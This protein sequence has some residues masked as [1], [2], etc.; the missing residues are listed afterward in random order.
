MSEGKDETPPA[1]SA[2]PAVPSAKAGPA[3]ISDPLIRQEARRAFVWLGMASLVA[4]C[5][6]L[7][8]PL[9]VIFGGIVFAAMI[10]GGVRLLGR[11][12]KIGHGWRVGIVLLLAV[13]FLIWTA[14]FAG[15]QIARQAAE[16]PA[17]L[18]S[19][20][21]AVLGWLEQQQLGLEI[22]QLKDIAG[23]VM[24]GIGQLSRAVGGIIGI[25]TT[26]FLILVLGI[27]FALEPH[28]YSRGVGWMLPR[29]RR[30]Y[31]GETAR[32]MGRSLRR[33]LAG[34]L[35]GMAITGTLTW[36]MLGLYG[37]PMAALLGLLTGLLAF[38]PNI[39]ALISGILIVLVGFSGG[40][41]MGLYAIFVYAFI[42]TVDGFIIGPQVARR[43]ADLPPALVLGAQL[44]MGVLFGFLGLILADPMVAMIKVWLERS[45]Q[46][47]Q[48][49]RTGTT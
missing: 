25:F 29:E 20:W 3:D 6:L 37:V 49:D 17:I 39:G 47:N 19:Q 27:Y 11:V 1:A 8:N 48:A 28:L 22:S 14:N 36:L 41:E 10:D 21:L 7:A 18:E 38:L 26:T 9:L 2:P 32:I 45:A 44:I 23:Q 42:Q 5:V 24:G 16:L 4:L 12:L 13:A 33:L 34:R 15:N 43:T 30:D 46:Q 35:L 31:F 40:I